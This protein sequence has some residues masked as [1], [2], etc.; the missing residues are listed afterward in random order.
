MPL[1]WQHVQIRSAPL[2]PFEAV[3]AEHGAVVLRVCRAL[4]APA[5]ADDAWSDTFLAALRAYPSLRPGSNIRGWLV[6]IAHR[7]AIDVI[8]R[9][10]R[11]AVPFG[12]LPAVAVDDRIAVLEADLALRDA[13][14]ALAPKQR[15]AVIYRYLADLSYDEVAEQLG[16]SVAA[17]RRNA[18]DGI[19]RL[20][21]LYPSAA[22]A[23]DTDPDRRSG[24]ADVP[25]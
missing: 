18:A 1:R 19:A 10:K 17:A 21:E 8:R 7:K 16:G 12:D 13:L 23:A 3:V 14:S 24:D 22:T 25:R 11:Q 9:G 5:D 6:T 20:R 4:L 2:P 15:E